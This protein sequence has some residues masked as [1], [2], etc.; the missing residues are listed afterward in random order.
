MNGFKIVFGE[1]REKEKENQRPVKDTDQR[2]PNFN[3][4]VVCYGIV[5]NARSSNSAVGLQ[6]NGHLLKRSLKADL[7]KDTV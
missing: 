7:Y 6:N 5:H 4:W 2:V 1:I 3:G